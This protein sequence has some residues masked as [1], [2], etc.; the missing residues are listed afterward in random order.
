MKQYPSL[1]EVTCLGRHTVDSGTFIQRSTCPDAIE[2]EALFGG[3]NGH[4][5]PRNLGDETLAVNRVDALHY[6]YQE[7]I[8]EI[9]VEVH[10]TGECLGT[11][12]ICEVHVRQC[13]FLW[14]CRKF[15]ICESGLLRAVHLSRH[16]WPGELVD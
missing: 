7:L 6:M 12:F 3:K 9:F 10:I 2:F 14:P 1:Q 15:K 4:V 11:W 16:K 8:R 5:T 13:S